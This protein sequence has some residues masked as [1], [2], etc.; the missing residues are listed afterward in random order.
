M[1]SAVILWSQECPPDGRTAAGGGSVDSA[2]PT[3]EGGGKEDG[4]VGCGGSTAAAF[5]VTPPTMH[6]DA[7]LYKCTLLL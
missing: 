4:G 6:Q 2:A 3:T 5:G 1:V 7:Q